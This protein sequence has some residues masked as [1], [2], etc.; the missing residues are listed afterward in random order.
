MRNQKAQ[1]VV[2][3]CELFSLG[4]A[5]VYTLNAHTMIIKVQR[6]PRYVYGIRFASFIISV[7][8]DSM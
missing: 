1:V 2:A 4:P 7:A 3:S 6:I 5:P 8:D